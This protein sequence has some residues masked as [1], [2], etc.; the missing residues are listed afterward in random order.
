MR[1]ILPVAGVALLLAGTALHPMHADPAVPEAA[2]AEYA[3]DRLWHL[4]HLTQ[5]LGAA[6]LAVSL[7]AVTRCDARTLP[8]VAAR[9]GAVAGVALSGVLQAVDGVALKRMVDLWSAASGGEREALFAGALAVRSIEVGLAAIYA[10]LMGLTLALFG[11]AIMGAPGRQPGLGLAGIAV[12]LALA[13]GG[14]MT[15]AAGFAALPMSVN[16][17]ASLAALGWYLVAVWRKPASP[18]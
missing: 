6:T 10:L 15:G 1:M 4:S 3:A 13:A 11:L 14:L 5:F 17:A 16:M 2:F 7:L 18:D 9:A 8:V 12:G